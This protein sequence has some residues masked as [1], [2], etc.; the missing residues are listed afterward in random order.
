M[1]Y[2][3]LTQYYARLENSPKRLEK[4]GIVRELLSLCSK[5]DL[6]LIMRLLLGKVFLQTSE[7]KTGVSTKLVIK[8]LSSV[9]GISTY[10]IEK[11]W[12]KIGDLGI[13]AEKL[14]HEKKQST[15]FSKSLTLKNVFE[16]ISDL[17]NKEGKGAV[18]QK[19]ALMKELLSSGSPIENK[20]LVRLFLEDL[21]IGVGE[22]VIRDAIV[23]NHHNVNYS[24]GK[25]NPES[26]EK[27]NEMVEAVKQAYDLTNDFVLVL[28]T[29]KEKGFAGLEKLSLVPG[30]PIN[31][32]LAIKAN[33]EKEAVDSVGLPCL[34]DY[35]LDGFRV[36]VHFD[37]KK[38]KLFTRKLEDVT[39]QFPEVVEVIKEKI[40]AN[41]YVL[42]AEIIG[43]D[44]KTEKHL[45]FQKISQ[46][47][48]RKYKIEEMIKKLPVELQVFDLLYWNSKSLT[49]LTQKERRELL[50]KVIPK[51]KNKLTYVTG[52]VAK[53]I[54][55]IK[56]FYKNAL[57]L[58]HEG[59]M[60]K[61]LSKHYT[62]GRKVG[63]WIKLKPTLENLDLVIVKAEWGTGKRGSWLSSFTVACKSGNEFYEVGKVST[64]AKEKSKGLSYEELTGL[65]KPLI[66]KE[67]GK[68]VEVHPK[69]IIEVAYEEIQKSNTYNSGYGLRFPRLI[70][71]REDKPL[72][73]IARIND[74]KHI[75]ETQKSR[76]KIT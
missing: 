65:L 27:Y 1:D 43:L 72:N 44:L 42:D 30:I 15:L 11:E 6:P 60:V 73:E 13:V 2:L 32:M 76:N 33:D 66:I 49:N 62:C 67:N 58:G 34:I 52:M 21:R 61:N 75:F 3:K 24:E 16:N 68:E 20:Y 14:T 10:V 54:E 50:T 19:I 57:E 51:V 4:T 69:I 55:E 56:Q 23:W 29:I 64:G 41:N 18:E 31:P 71:L 7:E 38:Y 63:G 74:I 46:R 47:I 9:T 37:G 70:R 36:E 53:N 25:I 8:A 26:R 35:K 40:K 17:S 5:R 12:I 28:E 22:S 59:I 45:P 48:K 39:K